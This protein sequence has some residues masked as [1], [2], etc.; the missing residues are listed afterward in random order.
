MSFRRDRRGFIFSLDA[1]LAMLV[2]MIV[3]AGVARV[4]GPELTYGQHGYL[5]LQRYANDTLE[6]MQLMGTIDNIVN[7][8]TDGEIEDAEELARTELRNILPREVQFKLRIG[9]E[10]SPRL[11][12][13]YPTPDNDK[14]Q[15]K[16][17][18]AKEI[19]VAA[20]V[21][22]FD[23]PDQNNPYHSDKWHDI[24]DEK[25]TAQ[26]F[27]A[28]LTGT[29]TKVA[30][31]L[32][33]DENPGV[34]TIEIR[35]CAGADD[36]PGSIVLASM[37]TSDVTSETG[38]EYKFTFTSPAS[39]TAGTYY[40]IVLH[41]PEGVG[42][43]GKYEWAEYKPSDIYLEGHAWKSKDNGGSWKWS[44]GGVDDFYFRTYVMGDTPE[45]MF[46]S[47]NLYVWRGPGI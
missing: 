22:A 5:R 27:V 45:N 41:E 33:K 9:S 29:L 8:V 37:T 6:V 26:N 21:S 31:Y 10:D 15:A 11:D 30:L 24:K 13:V 40:S 34:L 2:V 1:T 17:E 14:W 39:V 3:M 46:D 23:W 16:F 32:K 4:G 35:D 18:N 38:Q 19:A 25:W 36:P 28:G 44:G 7:L 43:Q 20:R 47:I 12:N 42:D